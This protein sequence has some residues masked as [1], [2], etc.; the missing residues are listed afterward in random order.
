MFHG[1]THY[2][3]GHFPWLFWHNRWFYRHKSW[4]IQDLNDFGSPIISYPGRL[5]CPNCLRT[6]RCW[7]FLTMT[8]A[9]KAFLPWR[10]VS[11]RSVLT[12]IY[13]WATLWTVFVLIRGRDCSPGLRKHINIRK[14]KHIPIKVILS[15]ECAAEKRP[16]GPQTARCDCDNTCNMV[17]TCHYV[18]RPWTF[19]YSYINIPWISP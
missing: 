13:L 14:E 2:F 5:W 8:S 12:A 1:K 11:R 16:D 19:V 4:V 18:I 9:W 17:I 15:R 3:N 10:I 7:T 6:R